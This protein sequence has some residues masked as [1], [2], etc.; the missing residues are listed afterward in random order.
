MRVVI[1]IPGEAPKSLRWTEQH[2]KSASG[3]G[4][5][6]YRHGAEI[7][8]GLHF[9]EA[10]ERGGWIETDRPDRVRRALGFSH[11]EGNI[12]RIDDRL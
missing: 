7:L 1:Y 2:P 12:R 8:D 3:A 6:L 9:M 5:L 10:Q 4:V 11:G